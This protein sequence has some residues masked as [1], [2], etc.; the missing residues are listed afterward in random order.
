MNQRERIFHLCL[1][2]GI[3]I[4]YMD[5]TIHYAT[6][7]VLNM[8]LTT[9]KIIKKTGLLGYPWCRRLHKL[10]DPPA[11]LNVV[12]TLEVWEW[13]SNFIPL[14]VYDYL[15]KLELKLTHVSK[16]SYSASANRVYKRKR[17]SALTWDWIFISICLWYHVKHYRRSNII[18]KPIS[19]TTIV[20]SSP[21]QK[22]RAHPS[23]CPSVYLSVTLLWFPHI[24]R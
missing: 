1:F 3:S 13:I 22:E 5:I 11:W 14:L 2:I 15:S 10:K 20:I 24:S 8:Q 16:R 21:Q 7:N 18:D 4:E 9:T 19:M 23:D 17:K 6:W 12:N